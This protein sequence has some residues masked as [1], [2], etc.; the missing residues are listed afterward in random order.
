MQI[1][2]AKCVFMAGVCGL[3]FLRN[4]E[5]SYIAKERRAQNLSIL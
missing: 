4:T 2:N 3:I 1:S 5:F